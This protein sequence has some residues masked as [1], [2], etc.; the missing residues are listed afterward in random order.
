MTNKKGML[1]VLSGPSGSGKDTILNELTRRETDVN[2]SVSM[3]TRAK[4]DCEIDGV[5]YYFVTREYFERTIA[6]NKALEYAEY[7]Q[8]LYGTPKA[9]VDEMLAAGKTVVLKIEVQGAERIRSLYPEAVSIFLMPPSMSVLE[10]RLRRRETNDEED[11]QRRLSIAADEIRRAT[12]YDY[13]VI[14]S[15]VDYAVSDIS[16]IIRAERQKTFRNKNIISEV[17]NNA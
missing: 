13:V 1:I 10:E 9:P 14:N 11:I 8:N 16:A 3:T 15:I 7:G 4:R 6:E 17:L 5:H 12:E 2:V